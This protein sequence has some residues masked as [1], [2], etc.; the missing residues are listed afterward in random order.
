GLF[1]CHLPGSN[2]LLMLIAGRSAHDPAVESQVVKCGVD[3]ESFTSLE[4]RMAAA[5]E[6]RESSPRAKGS[7]VTSVAD[8]KV[9]KSS[10]AR[11][12]IV[13]NLLKMNFLSSPSACF[14][15]VDHIHQVSDLETV[16]NGDIEM[17]YSDLLPMQSEHVN[18]VNMEG[19]EKQAVEEVEAEDDEAEEDA[20]DEVVK[21]IV[22]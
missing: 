5:K 6:T 7:F 3:S 11:D 2:I 16:S 20:A 19:D 12:A 13:S 22:D 1:H 10:L 8:P 9:D 17:L 15:L 21:N 4:M 14:K 18:A